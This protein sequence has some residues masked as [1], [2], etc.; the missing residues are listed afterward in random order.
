MPAVTSECSPPA[1]AGAP[2]VYLRFGRSGAGPFRTGRDAGARWGDHFTVTLDVVVSPP[3]WG[4]VFG[5]GDG[6]E[7]LSQTGRWTSSAARLGQVAAL[8]SQH[9][10]TK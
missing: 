8:Y 7:V 9:S 4:W 2:A 6:V 5:L 1:G 3:F 10:G